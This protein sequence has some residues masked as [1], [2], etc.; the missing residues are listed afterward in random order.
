MRIMDLVTKFSSFPISYL[1][2]SRPFSLSSLSLSFFLLLPYVILLLRFLSSSL[3]LSLLFSLSIYS[4]LSPLSH[5]AKVPFPFLF[6][7]SFSLLFSHSSWFPLLSPLPVSL[8]GSQ[9]LYTLLLFPFPCLLQFSSLSLCSPLSHS[10]LS[11][12]S[13]LPFSYLS[14]PAT[15]TSSSFFLPLCHPP[16][17]L[18]SSLPFSQSPLSLISHFPSSLPPSL[19]LFLSPLLPL[20]T[21]LSSS[22]FLPLCTF[23]PPLPFSHSPPPLSPLSPLSHPPSPLLPLSPLSHLPFPLLHS[24][25]SPLLPLSHLL[26]PPSPLSSPLISFSP[27]L[28]LS[29]LLSPLSPLSPYPI[30]LS[31]LSSPTIRKPRTGN[32]SQLL[33]KTKRPKRFSASC[34]L[35]STEIEAKRRRGNACRCLGKCAICKDAQELGRGACV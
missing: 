20:S 31:P 32:Y 11:S 19:F 17:P 29:P 30:P 12:S 15:L 5:F 35:L 16:P 4:F 22:F 25:L 1:L 13:L 3:L 34:L 26:S 10:K 18:S 7:L 21:L 9:L 8:I 2:S 27:L 23:F 24:P 33:T 6:P 28:T 14:P